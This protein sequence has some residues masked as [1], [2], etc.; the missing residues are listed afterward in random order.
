LKYFFLFIFINNVKKIIIKNLKNLK[1]MDKNK[2]KIQKVI[3]SKLDNKF[4][5]LKKI[6]ME[7]HHKSHSRTPK[8]IDLSY[9]DSLENDT[10]KKKR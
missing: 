3:K 8:T 10:P 5:T 7:N 4:P 1:I 6:R 2:T 9:E